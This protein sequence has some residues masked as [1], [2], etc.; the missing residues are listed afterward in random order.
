MCSFGK[1]GDADVPLERAFF[2]GVHG[3]GGGGHGD[4]VDYAG[5]VVGGVCIGDCMMVL[6]YG[7][8]G[9]GDHL[10]MVVF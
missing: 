6:V 5:C 9:Y 7:G 1:A 3:D 4:G 8:G 10:R 2:C